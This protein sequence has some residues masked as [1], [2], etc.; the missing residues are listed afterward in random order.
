MQNVP[1]A[2]LITLFVYLIITTDFCE[3]EIYTW[4]VLTYSQTF[5]F[6]STQ[7]IDFLFQMWK[8]TLF[9]NLWSD[10]KKKDKSEIPCVKTFDLTMSTKG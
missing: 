5:Q 4:V 9:S 3:S 8:L 6:Y 2:Y 10:L 1:Q 7:R